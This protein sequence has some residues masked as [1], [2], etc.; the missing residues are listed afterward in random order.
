VGPEVSGIEDFNSAFLANQIVSR[1]RL[2][3]VIDCQDF[4]DAEQHFITFQERDPQWRDHSENIL[5]EKSFFG[6][7]IES[8]YRSTSG[9]W[10][11]IDRDFAA[12]LVKKLE[13]SI[14]DLF[15]KEGR[16]A[17]SFL[18]ASDSALARQEKGHIL[19]KAAQLAAAFYGLTLVIVGQ[20]GR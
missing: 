20:P 11:K 19:K 10:R 2:I 14:D 16:G 13:F 18:E 4:D 8:L 9:E 5:H 17:K 1:S 15:L 6:E 3:P 7:K 12:D